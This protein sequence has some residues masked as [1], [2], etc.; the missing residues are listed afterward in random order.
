MPPNPDHEFDPE[1]IEETFHFLEEL[2]GKDHVARVIEDAMYERTAWLE[3]DSEFYPVWSTTLF[4]QDQ[5]WRTHFNLRSS[6]DRVERLAQEAAMFVLIN[7]I[8]HDS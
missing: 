7:D 8:A 3:S 5:I 1:E 6:P 4:E 2:L